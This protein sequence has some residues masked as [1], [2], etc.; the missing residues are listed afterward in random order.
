MDFFFG[1]TVLPSKNG[2]TFFFFQHVIEK[3]WL[4]YGQIRSMIEKIQPYGQIRANT[5]I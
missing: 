3:I 1:Q 5:G 4:L 2:H